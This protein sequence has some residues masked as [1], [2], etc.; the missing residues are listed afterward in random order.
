[1]DDIAGDLPLASEF[2]AANEAEWRKRV[3]EVLKGRPFDRL[4]TTTHDGLRIEPL[5]ARA[6]DARP[7]VGR[8]GAW[9]VMQRVDHPEP[10][11][12]NAQALEDLE[13]GATGLTLTIAGAAD[14][15]GFGIGPSAKSLAHVLDGVQ[16]DAG[17]AIELALPAFVPDAARNLAAVVR[18]SGVPPAA[19]TIRF[20]LDPLASAARTGR[21]PR[22][23][24]E[25]AKA[26]AAVVG[27]LAAQ[28]F[29]GPFAASD[30]RVVHA[31]GGSEA[32]ELAFALA[33][34]VAYL[35][36]L[37]ASGI[38]LADAAGMVFFHLAADADQLMTI[39]KL[40]AMRQLWAR[41]E[42]S[43]GL[44]PRQAFVSVTTAWRMMTRRDP[45][46]NLLRTTI[47]AFSAALGGADAI[48]VLPFTAAL[49]LAE[50]FARRLARNTQLLLTEE[51]NLARV[52]D[53][54]AG[55][56][57]IH[58][59]TDALCRRAWSRFQ[60]IEAD[61]GAA[62]ALLLGSL[63]D[64]IASVRAA[65]ERAV[66]HRTDS[67]IGTTD[68][69]DL[70]ER[71]AAVLDVRPN[72]TAAAASAGQGGEAF[73]PLAPMRLAE[74]FER[75]RDAADR[76][77]GADGTPPKVFLANL[78]TPADFNARATFAKNFF[79]AGGI[80]AVTNDGFADISAMAAAFKASGASLAC[81][82]ASDTLYAEASPAAEALVRTGAK[83]LYLAGRP[84]E[85][86]GLAKAGVNAFIFTGCDALAT[87]RAA[88]D[89]LGVG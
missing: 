18:A 70:A 55:A 67:L 69:A 12:A 71:P 81:L 78:G 34:G 56:G 43:C 37:E 36:A 85:T 54:A 35:R 47:A 2:S 25:Q 23:W 65:R 19:V 42:E 89:I 51:S 16:L 88:H 41:V 64:Q 39:A 22:P 66:A 73:A 10:A 84:K 1:M 32:Q 59:M 86:A 20:G 53:P 72:E 40:R 49:G 24:A 58:Q 76:M 75:L 50:P 11:A 82:C 63:A 4:T 31:A 5:Y 17:I 61:A 7:L 27:E 3:E 9:Q 74:P 44:S 83:R 62:A 45:H 26:F 57:A 21:M 46:V 38:A 30:G 29:S 15:H 33:S 14:A 68:F 13:N 80:E 77:R 28:G 48:T 87:L 60:E 52:A 6:P 8:A 79:A